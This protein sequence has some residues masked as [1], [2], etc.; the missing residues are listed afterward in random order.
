VAPNK[1]LRLKD[2]E[3]LKDKVPVRERTMSF[4]PPTIQQVIDYCQQRR[5]GVDPQ[6]WFDHYT[7]N[8]WKVGRN[9]M[10]DWKAAVRNWEQ[11]GVR[12]ESTNG[13]RAERRQA[14]NIAAGEQALEILQRRQMAN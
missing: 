7:S 3:D 4:Q 6:R 2:E 10:K 11:N 14:D 5:K 8:G 1:D 13:N 12:N 9:S